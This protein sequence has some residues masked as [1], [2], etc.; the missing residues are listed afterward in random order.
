V[1]VNQLRRQMKLAAPSAAQS[2]VSKYR[3]RN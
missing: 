2:T 3:R 1:S